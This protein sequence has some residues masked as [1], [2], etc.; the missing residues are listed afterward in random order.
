MRADELS[1]KIA[2]WWRWPF[3]AGIAILGTL[4][5]MAASQYNEFTRASADIDRAE[6]ITRAVDDLMTVLVNAETGYRGYLLSGN[7]I[8]LEPY[9]G[10]DVSARTAMVTLT[11]LVAGDTLQREDL[12]RL[13][14]LVEER[15]AEMAG[16]VT[17]YEA[18]DRDGAIAS[19]RTATG[20]RIMDQ[21]RIVG[22]TLKSEQRAITS[23]RAAQGAAAARAARRFGI[24][25]GSM[26]LL[27]SFLGWALSRTMEQRR[28]ELATETIARLEA[29]RDATISA[30]DLA[31]SESFNRTLL[32]S[33]ADCIAVLTSGGDV[34]YLNLAGE[35]QLLRGDAD[36]W[37]QV[38]FPSLWPGHSDAAADAMRLAMNGGE[39]R[40]VASHQHPDGLLRWWDVILT[41]ARDAD[42]QVLR[43]VATA[44]DITQQRRADEERL[45]LLASEREARSA[46]ERA[47]R[48]KD[49]FVS[50]LSHEL[51][52]PLNAILGWVG[53]LRQDQ[54][55]D[56]LTKAIDVIDR[57]SRRQSQ[58]IDDLLD[59]GRILSG[60]MRLEVQRVE[61]AT[62]IEEAILSAQPSADAKGVRL[63]KTLGS[64]AIVRGDSGRLQQVVWNLLSNAI[65][66][67]PRGG[68]VQVTLRKV[69]SQVHV[70]VSDTGAGIAPDLVEHVFDRFRQ[71]DAS[72]TRRHGGLG[73]GLSIVK[74]LVELHGGSVEA[75]SDGEQAGAT[76]TVRLPLALASSQHDSHVDQP[77]GE[78]LLTTSLAGLRV[79][80]LDDEEDA[81]D[82]VTRL[83]EDAGAAVTAAGSA[84]DAQTLL[85]NGLV[86]DVVV[87]D[88]GMPE[89]DGYDFIQAV[90]RMPPPLR[91]VPAA[92]LTALAR[93]EDRKRALLSG[94]QTHLAKPVDP[95]ELVA[96]VASLAG[97][98]GRT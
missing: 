45:A 98:T 57:N 7:P 61:L 73:L 21:I 92:A 71:G 93:L 47:A 35:R 60:K 36:P 32:D 16:N 40:F 12:S 64:A 39:G 9:R 1:T 59:M 67:T 50:T 84:S 80:V 82:V 19:V 18:G 22:G 51:R 46:A 33:S 95:A 65:K 96:T 24:A 90:R 5:A 38:A 34:S 14:G 48:I 52:T 56:T 85:E 25:A 4:G 94:F 76:F 86:P 2:S 63:L 83:L 74:S 15:L 13:S 43:L 49:D 62:V 37:Q 11:G 44:R 69:N 70:Q 77:S 88:V 68:Q 28:Q 55:P 66:F 27:L 97:R 17:R 3:I 31:R 23:N 53:V 54:Q 26:V 72:T 20:K 87:S 78:P 91:T 42:G 81:R 30:A 58:M 29:E 89:R 79:L 6:S 10:V 75:A 8:F 41:P